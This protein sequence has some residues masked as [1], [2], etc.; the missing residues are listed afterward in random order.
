MCDSNEEVIDLIEINKSKQQK[1]N[2]CLVLQKSD[3]QKVFNKKNIIDLI[4]IK[5]HSITYK[6]IMLLNYCLIA[7]ILIKLICNSV[8][9]NRNK[10]RFN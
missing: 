9:I 1:T 10:Y 4:A 8:L 2:E 3:N 6:T 7:L 5:N